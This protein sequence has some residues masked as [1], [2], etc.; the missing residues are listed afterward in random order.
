MRASYSESRLP[1]LRTSSEFLLSEKV[2]QRLLWVL[3]TKLEVAAQCGT[4]CLVPCSSSHTSSA[5]ISGRIGRPTLFDLLEG[6]HT[7]LSSQ[8]QGIY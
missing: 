3:E 1:T 4:V 2:G 8:G 5:L 7:R 6:K